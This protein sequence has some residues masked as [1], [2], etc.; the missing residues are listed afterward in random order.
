MT[1][2]EVTRHEARRRLHLV[3]AI[4]CV[5]QSGADII[6]ACREI[7]QGI[8][9]FTRQPRRRDVQIANEIDGDGAVQDGQVLSD[10]GCGRC[11]GRGH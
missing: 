5:E 6:R 11:P 7:V 4:E 2:R 10:A 3:L 9:S 1:Q 8:V